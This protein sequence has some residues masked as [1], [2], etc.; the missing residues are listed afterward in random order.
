MVSIITSRGIFLILDTNIKLI[1]ILVLSN[2]CEFCDKLLNCVPS[3]G[4]TSPQV[5]CSKTLSVTG[6]TV[7]GL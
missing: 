5:V 6:R 7:I 4:R 1:L 3:D 2:S